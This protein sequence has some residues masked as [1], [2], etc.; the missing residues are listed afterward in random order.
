MSA[1]VTGVAAVDVDEH[2]DGIEQLLRPLAMRA[3]QTV[4]VPE[5][6]GLVLAEDVR[7][8]VDLPVFRNS[9]MD[10]YAVRAATV[11]HTPVTLT[12]AGVVAAGEPGSTPLPDGGAW[13]VM[14]GAPIPPGADCVVPV[15]DTKVEDG[16][17][18]I[19]RGRAAGDFI[20][21]PGTDVGAGELL[22]AAGTG[23]TPR[24]IAALAA[25][26]VPKVAVFAPVRAAI[27]TTGDELVPAGTPLRPGQIYN[28]NGIAL[29]AVLGADRVHVVS[30]QHSTDDPAVFTRLLAAAT[31]SADVV[32]TSG[33]VSKGDFEVVKEVLAA[34]GGRFGSV[35]MQPGGPQGVSVVDGVPVLSF[36]GNPVSTLVSYEVLARPMLRTLSGLPPMREFETTL[37]ESVRSPAGRRQFL[38]GRITESGVETVSGPGSHLIAGM[39]RADVLVDIPAEVTELAAGATVVVREL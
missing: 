14:T 18:V 37:S 5:A 11:R 17:V 3:L 13:K 19:E 29:A 12:L 20:R 2:R 26:G 4:P 1:R 32:F 33:G 10:G 9:A 16:H 34:R 6:T 28:S 8:P 24:H 15:E 7:A 21:E 36:P 31:A 23:L 27:L 25:V 22:V 35:A 30:V 38:R 39:A